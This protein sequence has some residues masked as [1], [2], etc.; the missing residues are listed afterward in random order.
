MKI[1]AAVSR[2]S[3]QPFNLEALELDDPL[4]N[5]VLVRI[6]G[7]G[8]CHTD[9]VFRDQAVPHP[10]P[11]VYGHEGSGV[12]ER[13]GKAVTKIAPG[14][15]VVLT[16]SSCG[17][18]KSCLQGK[19]S[20]CLEFGKLNVSGSRPN[21]EA[22]LKDESGERVCGCFFGQSSFASHALAHERNVVKIPRDVPLE[23]MGPL[24]CGIQTGA[25][26]I[27]NALQPKAGSSVVIFG[28]GSVGLAAVLAATIR[29]CYPIIVV[30]LQPSRLELAIALGGTHTVNG[31]AVDA[32][33]AIRAITNEQGA[34]FTVECTG[35]PKV[36][37]QAVDALAI[38][39]VCGVVGAAPA[40][41]EVALDINSVL[42]GRTV[43][44]VMEGDSI[45]ELF[46]PQLIEFWRQGKFPFDRLIKFYPLADI[47]KA[48]D[49]SEHGGVLK[50]VMRP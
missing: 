34:D 22:T 14:D 28:A 30:D 27:L 17:Q 8:L 24:G 7:V 48:I 11:A 18:C 47:N 19:P 45:P 49:D 13:V 39:G 44:G 43:K 2:Q 20:Y 32:V 21:G 3:K 1:H 5:E 16:F 12:V 35:V 36:V 4:D 42:M 15:H 40:G 33:A 23:L 25:G 46:I 41:A 37:R 26:A 6:V 38:G 29:G 50:A 31:G 10:L 9:V